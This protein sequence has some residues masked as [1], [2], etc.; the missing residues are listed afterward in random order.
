M[1]LRRAEDD[2]N[3]WETM[4]DKTLEFRRD[5]SGIWLAAKASNINDLQV[6]VVV[7][8]PVLAV[9]DCCLIFVLCFIFFIVLSV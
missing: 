1:L 4:R 3:S 2:K 5:G 6:N 8:E 7:L 9:L